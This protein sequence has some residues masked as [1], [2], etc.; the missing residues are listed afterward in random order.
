LPSY[1]LRF[2]SSHSGVIGPL[3]S[4]GCLGCWEKPGLRCRFSIAQWIF[5]ADKTGLSPV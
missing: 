3:C 4:K 1:S 2:F 5:E